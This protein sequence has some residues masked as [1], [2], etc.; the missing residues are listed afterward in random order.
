MWLL[1]VTVGCDR[2][3]LSRSGTPGSAGGASHAAERHSRPSGTA[4]RVVRRHAGRA[5]RDAAT[6]LPERRRSRRPCTTCSSGG[7]SRAR[8]AP[9]RDDPAASATR[10]LMTAGRSMARRV[11]LPVAWCVVVAAA[12]FVGGRPGRTAFGGLDVAVCRGARRHL[13]PRGRA[14]VA[15]SG[16]RGAARACGARASGRRPGPSWFPGRADRL[17]FG[18][19]AHRA[20]P[21]SGRRAGRCRRRA[22]R[23]AAAIAGLATVELGWRSS[24][25]SRW[26]WNTGG[27]ARRRARPHPTPRRR[28]DATAARAARSDRAHRSPSPCGSCCRPSLSGWYPCRDDAGRYPRPVHG[29]GSDIRGRA[30]VHGASDME[31]FRRRCS[32]G[33]RQGPFGLPQLLP[34]GLDP[35]VVDRGRPGGLRR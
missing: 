24:G 17:G 3:A 35:R 4:R 27:R 28:A 19:L 21:P 30:V 16:T 25:R 29:L 31:G 9:R 6:A 15:P 22:P 2:R 33:G 13:D 11:L 34:R 7:G 23:A 18:R 12:A 20:V 5:T 8:S 10:S 1:Q 14:A 32:A 26:V